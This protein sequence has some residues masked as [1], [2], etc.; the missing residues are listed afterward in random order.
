MASFGEYL[1][2]GTGGSFMLRYT[3]V[4]G[5]IVA[6][7]VKVCEAMMMMMIGRNGF[8]VV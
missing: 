2:V 3:G 8:L 4:V 7:A 1:P 6:G 5:V